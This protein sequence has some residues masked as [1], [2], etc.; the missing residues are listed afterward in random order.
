MTLKFVKWEILKNR[1]HF[2]EK[3]E[4]RFERSEIENNFYEE[5]IS[6]IKKE[7]E[8]IEREKENLQKIVFNIKNYDVDNVTPME[9]MKFL[10]ELKEK[11]KNN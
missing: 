11:I 9:A 8:N 5:K 3:L 4:V 6:E 2:E 7:K 10:F 1:L